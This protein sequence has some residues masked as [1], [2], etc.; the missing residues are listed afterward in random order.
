MLTAIPAPAPHVVA[1]RIENQI[2]TGDIDSALSLVESCLEKNRRV[3]L[4]VDV[5]QL[6]GITP[7]AF[8]KDLA[9][10]LKN[11]GRLYRFQQVA[12]I[13]DNATLEKVI[14]WEDKI[15]R[16]MEIKSFSSAQVN[17][18]TAW[19]ERRAELPPPGFQV[20]QHDTHLIFHLGSEV[21]GHD[22]THIAD[23]IHDQYEKHGPVSMLVTL[24]KVPKFGPGYIYEKL[25]QFNLAG[26]LARYAVIGPSALRTAIAAVNPVMKAHLKYFE[27]G[28]KEAAVAWLLDHSPSAEALPSQRMDRFGF[29]ISGK[30][31]DHEVEQFYQA[32]LPRLQGENSLDVILE[33]PYEDGITL[34]AIFKAIKLGLQ[35]FSKV[36]QGVRRLA[37]ITDSR[38]LTKASE[39]E[40]LLIP[41]VEERP[42]TFAQRDVAVAWLNEGRPALTS[43]LVDDDGV[44]D[45]E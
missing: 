18:A 13:T 2:D 14:S 25:R 12:V 15:F 16:N 10:S 36:T 4:Y 17:E 6:T 21:S 34:S 9:Y 20:E 30:I 33:V 31:T 3:N 28:Q 38:F 39:V 26:F 24:D 27:P 43:Q 8:L 19:I 7:T 22:V 42:F 32:L 35:N 1:A 44:P 29:R 45:S 5:S 40:N 37:V 11:L 41:S 23:L